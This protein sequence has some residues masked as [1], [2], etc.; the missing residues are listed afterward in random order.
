MNTKA[1]QFCGAENPLSAT[2]CIDCGVVLDSGGTAATVTDQS[3]V[4]SATDQSL[5][6]FDTQAALGTR[7]NLSADAVTSSARLL[8]VKVMRSGVVVMET[9]FSQNKI[10]VGRA[11]VDDQGFPVFPD[12]D[13]TDID[14]DRL[15]SRRHLCLYIDDTGIRAEDLGSGNGSFIEQVGKLTPNVPSIVP[16][17]SRIM[18]GRGG[19]VLT[20]TL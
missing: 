17:G 19:V 2:S 11:D 18:L 12:L 9:T 7:G 16:S 10:L 3:Q 1:C 15:V 14:Q 20:A 13:L 8:S 5:N 4:V 6:I